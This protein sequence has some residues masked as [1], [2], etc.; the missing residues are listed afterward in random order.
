MPTIDWTFLC[1]YTAVDAAGKI[2][3]IGVF[4]NINVPALPFKYPQ[5]YIAVNLKAAAGEKFELSSRMSAPNGT[6]IAKQGPIKIAIPANAPS[7]GKI[8]CTFAYF[9]T[10]FSEAGTHH[11]E[12]FINDQSVHMIPLNVILHQMQKRE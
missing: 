8:Y 12:I 11:I 4:E 9:G 3:I 10:L 5:I 1:D 6:E 2:S 7:A